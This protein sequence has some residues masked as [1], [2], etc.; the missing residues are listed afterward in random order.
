M[1]STL[2]VALTA[3][4]ALAACSQSEAPQAAAPA[5]PAATPAAGPATQPAAPVVA[6][7]TG[8]L[9]N[10][11]RAGIYTYAEVQVT[12]G[13]TIWIAGGNLE[14]QPGDTVQWGDAAVMRNFTAKSLN[15]TFPEILFV[16][17]WS[18]VGGEPAKMVAHGMPGGAGP[19]GMV[20]NHP[21]MGNQAPTGMPMAAATGSNSGVVKSVA[22]AGGYTYLEVDQRGKVVW[23]AAPENP[24]IQAGKEVVWAPGPV[25]SNFTAKSLGRTFDSIV[26]AGSVN[27]K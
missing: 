17:Q 27:V 10:I 18:K 16:S 14:A 19:V 25:M 3:A 6:L 21:P 13:R 2:F 8:K 22:S 26:F 24:S 12:E 1:K 15:R 5:A 7:N 20:P 4:L 23:V 11:E 9:V